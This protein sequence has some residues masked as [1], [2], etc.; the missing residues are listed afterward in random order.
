LAETESGTV[1]ERNIETEMRKS[2]L[3]YAMSVIVGRALPDARDG[4]KP[5]H[6]RVLFAMREMGSGPRSPYKKSARIV[7]DTMGKYHPHGDQAIYDTM[8]RMAQD[9]SLRYPLVD[10]QGNFGSV[11][12]DRAAAMRYTESR[13]APIAE[14]VLRDIDEDTVDFIDNYDGSL[15]E[16]SVLPG[17]LP[18]LLVNGSAGIAVGMA[19]NMPPHNLAEVVEALLLQLADPGVSLARIM[20]VLP[21]PDFPTGGTIMGR[22]GIYN[23]FSKGQGQIK[24]RGSVAHEEV[25]KQQRLIIREIPYGL[26]K[27]RLLE[28]IS[29]LVRDKK[30]AGIR[31]LRDES[32]RHGMRVVVELKQDASP[33]IVENLLFKHSALESS[34]AVNAVALVKGQPV[35]LAL[36]QLLAVYLEHRREVVERRSRYRLKK[37]QERGHIVEGLLLAI[38]QLDAIIDFIRKADGRDAVVAGLQTQF[39]LSEPQAKA[40]AEMRLYQLSRQ[41]ADARRDELA[42][43]KATITDLQDVLAR[44]ERV[45]EIIRTEL[46][47]LKEKYGDERRTEISDWEGDI[48]TEDLIPRS[49]V[50]VMRTQE[51]YIKRVELDEYR[52]QRRGGKGRIGIKAKEGDT[53]VE[54]YSLGSHDHILF[55]TSDGSMYFL[56]AWQI[57]DVS[58]YAKG[59]PL[60]QLLEKLDKKR[61]KSNE[62]VLR[63]LPVANLEA[64]GHYLVL[65]TRNG[66]VKRTRLE[67]FTKRIARGWKVDQGFRAI[68]LKEG[69]ELIDVAISDGSSQ[70]MFATRNGMANRASEGEIRVVG[71]G[72]Q[73]VIGIRLKEGD[74]VISMALV[75]DEGILLT[76]TELGYGKRASV[77]NYRLTKRGARGVLNLKPDKKSGAVIA[78]LPVGEAQQLLATTSSGKVIRTEIDSI[79]EIKRIG[80]GVKVM[81]L[82]KGEKVVAVA[83]HTEVESDNDELVAADEQA[84]AAG[85]CPECRS[86]RLKPDGDKLICGT[87]GLIIDA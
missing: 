10:G 7:G 61:H 23:A 78:C 15:Q 74:S 45:S 6:R 17:V 29:K 50:V 84:T 35:R 9:F 38:S 11:D 8:V 76:I 2:Y 43:L 72:G 68:T 34:F 26:Q 63:M 64:E 5:V 19:T 31:D 44:T 16:P 52:A 75:D 71:R 39:N 20:E 77:A 3:E 67:E 37:A 24:L 4:L 36:P 62:K 86:G 48:D 51:G 47:E 13:L 85:L 55:F 18:G 22:Q 87:C 21:G 32:D 69:D 54:I 82:E 81:S 57:P 33:Q 46:L 60:V 25:G 70:V 27:N 28:E 14:T 83:L 1:L 66:I 53:P 41:D 80:R 65:A 58:R 56:K 79:R 49:Q 42:E 59:T 73:G 40:I 12:G 30:V